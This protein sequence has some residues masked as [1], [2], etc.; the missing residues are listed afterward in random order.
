MG[1]A[2]K[3]FAPQP[4]G[5]M[6][7]DYCRPCPVKKDTTQAL[8][9]NFNFTALMGFPSSKTISSERAKVTFLNAPPWG[10][11]D[12]MV[13]RLVLKPGVQDGGVLP[14]R[15]LLPGRALGLPRPRDGVLSLSGG[16]GRMH[17]EGP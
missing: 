8:T 9:V 6:P 2:F 13:F 7:V 4:R 17:A 1:N 16:D 10:G 5:L 15:A 14:D 3:L 11:D 12:E